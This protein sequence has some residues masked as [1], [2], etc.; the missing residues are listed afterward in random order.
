MPAR[1]AGTGREKTRSV[2]RNRFATSP[3]TRSWVQPELSFQSK[4]GLVYDLQQVNSRRVRT[5][6]VS[7]TFF[8]LTEIR[9][10][11]SDLVFSL[12]VL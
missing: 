10:Y 3:Y 11:L 7:S 8:P 9:S 2:R 4:P 5:T 12:L 1:A 6:S